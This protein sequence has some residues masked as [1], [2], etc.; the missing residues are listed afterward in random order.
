MK[1]LV[2]MNKYKKG[3]YLE[4]IKLMILNE[5]QN[6]L[7]NACNSLLSKHLGQI[8]ASNMLTSKQDEASK[9]LKNED[10]ENDLKESET[11]EEKNHETDI[12]E[13]T[14]KKQDGTCKI[15]E[16]LGNKE[17]MSKEDVNNDEVEEK[18]NT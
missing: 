4:Q 13:E 12:D 5:V 6:E 16:N 8:L 10:E 7:K 9:E 15:E 17:E 2:D 11:F 3:A 14:E 1:R 18:I